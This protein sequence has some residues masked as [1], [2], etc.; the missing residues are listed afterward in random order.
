HR[1]GIDLVFVRSGTNKG[2]NVYSSV[3]VES[4]PCFLENSTTVTT[5]VSPLNRIQDTYWYKRV[6]ILLLRRRGSDNGT[7]AAAVVRRGSSNILNMY[8]VQ[9]AS[10]SGRSA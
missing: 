7:A 4:P 10:R 9:G 2:R 3:A 5:V 6:V 8:V 1:P